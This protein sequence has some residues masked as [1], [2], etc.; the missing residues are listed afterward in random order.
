MESFDEYK[1][2]EGIDISYLSAKIEERQLTFRIWD[3]NG[4]KQSKKPLSWI[5]GN[6]FLMILVYDITNKESFEDLDYWLDLQNN[7]PKMNNIIFV[8]NKSDMKDKR[9]VS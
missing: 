9:Q 6:T 7:Y 5:L 3:I 1:P 2:T 8:G 4:D